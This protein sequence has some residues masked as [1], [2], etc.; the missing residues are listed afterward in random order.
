MLRCGQAAVGI[1]HI[2]DVLGRPEHVAVGRRQDHVVVV[3]HRRV[4]IPH[5]AG[6]ELLAVHVRVGQIGHHVICGSKSRTVDGEGE[7]LLRVGED[8]LTDV[9]LV[10]APGL[11]QQLLS[12]GT[13]EG[14]ELE[15]MGGVD[16]SSVGIDFQVSLVAQLR[17]AAEEAVVIGAVVGGV[18]I[19]HPVVQ[20]DHG[21][22]AVPVVDLDAAVPN[23]V[24]AVGLDAQV[25]G[26]GGAGELGEV[27]GIV[28]PLVGIRLEAHHHDLV[29]VAE[30][31][32]AD[33]HV[34]G[35]DGDGLHL[36]IGLLLVRM[37]ADILGIGGILR[38][39]VEEE[40]AVAHG[41]LIGQGH[42]L[43]H[44][45]AAVDVPLILLD[46]H[47][48]HG[49]DHVEH[50][51]AAVG[52][53]GAA[54]YVH[55]AA[56]VLV[57]HV[58]VGGVLLG[59]LDDGVAG[60]GGG[61]VA[62]EGA[63]VDHQGAGVVH[64][65][66][67]A[68]DHVGDAGAFVR[69]EQSH[70]AV[71][72][73]EGAVHHGHDLVLVD[74]GVHDL[75]FRLG[76]LGV[77][78]ILAGLLVVGL[79]LALLGALALAVGDLAV[80]GVL[81]FA[82]GLGAAGV[83]VGAA[84]LIGRVLGGHVR[85][86]L[87]VLLHRGGVDVVLAAVIT[88]DDVL[89]LEGLQQIL[90]GGLSRT[91]AGGVLG[92]ADA[93]P[94]RAA[95]DVF[96]LGPGEVL[97]Q[98]VLLAAGLVDAAVNHQRAVHVEQVAGGEEVHVVLMGIHHPGDELDAAGLS[99]RSE[100]IVIRALRADVIALVIGTLVGPGARVDDGE[101]GALVDREHHG[102]VMLG[103]GA[104][105]VVAV[106]PVGA[107]RHLQFVAVQIQHLVGGDL[108]GLPL[109]A[110]LVVAVKVVVQDDVLVIRVLRGQEIAQGTR[111]VVRDRQPRRH[112][113]PF[114]L[115]GR[116]GDESRTDFEGVSL[117]VPAHLGQGVL[118]R[119]DL[120][121][122]GVAEV[123]GQV[124]VLAGEM[125]RLAADVRRLGGGLRRFGGG[126]RGLRRGDHGQG[127]RG[128]D[129]QRHKQH[130]QCAFQVFHG[131]LLLCGW[132]VCVVEQLGNAYM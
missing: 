78:V 40:L 13:V 75:L 31:A 46:L 37:L 50:V 15:G 129:H 55:L 92:D 54:V 99:D 17:V 102:L 107:V 108:N 62:L 66:H 122:L 32:A 85:A 73:V 56:V 81:G 111:L 24:L 88:G 59:D 28:V 8:R 9:L 42:R 90:V 93:Q 128:D 41:L 34:L 131:V 29:V 121:C 71:H 52:L 79:V 23:H 112:V 100:V 110:A 113:V 30:G 7:I 43:G 96:Q 76:D 47:V 126:L 80:L 120:V 86:A 48:V 119:A 19:L 105:T 95:D 127:Q 25:D 106:A 115:V 116:G 94:H 44:D 67:R 84:L 36:G 83:G 14:P 118:R 98:L 65:G 103:M 27:V 18:V 1:I 69:A 70:D 21:A 38:L 89:R 64:V 10:A 33:H 6:V 57:G 58:G 51:G 117:A 132:D 39:I 4:V 22:V 60:V 74:D 130:A 63:A 87:A 125:R 97:F 5:L 109:G 35:A 101:G 45:V 2:A 114:V 82:D 53:K 3:V 61:A 16:S 123:D 72:Q 68:L 91:D 20:Q 104:L 77:L 12:L 49:A 11:A 124:R 26:A